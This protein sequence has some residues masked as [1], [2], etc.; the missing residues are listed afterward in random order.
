M[1]VVVTKKA[2]TILRLGQRNAWHSI[3]SFSRFRAMYANTLSCIRS[4]VQ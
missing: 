4:A 1:D 2:L 3:V